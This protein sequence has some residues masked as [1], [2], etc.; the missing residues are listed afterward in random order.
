MLNRAIRCHPPKP[1]LA[2]VLVILIFALAAFLRIDFL[3]SVHHKVSHDSIY[4]D[5]MVRQL[6]ET[7]VYAYKDT[8]PNAQVTPGYPLFMAAVYKLADYER[9]D[10][11]RQSGTPR[12]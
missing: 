7:G 2:I 8:E 9:Q 3:T 1:R 12:W 11:F 6:L 4:Y 5:E 10:P